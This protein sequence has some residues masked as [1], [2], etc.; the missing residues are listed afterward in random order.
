MSGS[1]QD[2]IEGINTTST[3]PPASTDFRHKQTLAKGGLDHVVPG[4]SSSP[5]KKT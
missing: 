5:V 4:M 2:K 3:V 1:S